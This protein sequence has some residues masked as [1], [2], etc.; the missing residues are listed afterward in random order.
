MD[1]HTLT[2]PS[3]ISAGARVVGLVGHTRQ[4]GRRGGCD[5]RDIRVYRGRSLGQQRAADGRRRLISSWRPAAVDGAAAPG[6]PALTSPMIV[7]VT[8]GIRGVTTHDAGLR[9]S[10]RTTRHFA[11]N[12]RYRGWLLPV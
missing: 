4:L 5:E 3:D 9:A 11:H 2:G 12:G 7:V 1:G 6:A 8:P 10:S